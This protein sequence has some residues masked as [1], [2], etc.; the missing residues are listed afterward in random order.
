MNLTGDTFASREL[1]YGGSMPDEKSDP[2]N[3]EILTA[4]QGMWRQQRDL[5]QGVEGRLGAKLDGIEE[6]LDGKLAAT[7]QR[8]G[9][10]L[11]Q[12]I[13]DRPIAAL[14]TRSSNH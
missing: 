8:L 9:D 4:L 12:E 13:Q 11:A 1:D 7:E 14:E 10:R 2:N 6:Q 5:I 3:A